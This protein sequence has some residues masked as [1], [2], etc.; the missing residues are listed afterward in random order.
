MPTRT[1]KTAKYS[2]GTGKK[3]PG[4]AG[5]HTGHTGHTGTDGHTDHT[6]EPH[7]HP[8]PTTHPHDHVTAETAAESTAARTAAGPEPVLYKIRNVLVNLVAYVGDCGS[9]NYT[10]KLSSKT[11]SEQRL[12]HTPAGRHGPRGGRGAGLACIRIANPTRLLELSVVLFRG[13]GDAVMQVCR[14]SALQEL[15]TGPRTGSTNRPS[16]AQVVP[17][18]SGVL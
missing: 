18:A 13:P 1:P 16:G 10:V 2:T 12:F 11:E 17:G 7:N 6:D 8:N 3:T 14:G 4:G 15:R 9:S 5:T